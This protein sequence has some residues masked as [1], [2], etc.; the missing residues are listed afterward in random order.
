MIVPMATQPPYG[1]GAEINQAAGTV[2]VQANC[3]IE[4][5]FV[6]MFARA[7][8]LGI[9]IFEVADRVLDRSITF[10]H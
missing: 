7:D 5:A 6:L 8:T 10:A 3:L 1:Y 2:S 4:D 9:S